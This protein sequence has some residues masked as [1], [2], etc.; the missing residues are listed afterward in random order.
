MLLNLFYTNTSLLYSISFGISTG[1]ANAG[2]SLSVC[3]FASVKPAPKHPRMQCRSMPQ[4][5]HSKQCHRKIT[6]CEKKNQFKSLNQLENQ[7]R[8]REYKGWGIH[9]TSRKIAEVL[10][11]VLKAPT[12]EMFVFHTAIN[13]V[14]GE[15]M[16]QWG[17]IFGNFSTCYHGVPL[18]PHPHPTS[19][20]ECNN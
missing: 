15:V 18:S 12:C 19:W 9:K 3:K 8:G 4:C 13:K 10:N 20:R 14:I 5:Q 6:T 11:L 1:Y 17:L 2:L 7:R 16:V